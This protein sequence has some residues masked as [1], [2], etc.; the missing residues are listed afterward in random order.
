MNRKQ[1]QAIDDARRLLGL[2]D[3]ATQGEIKRAYHGLCKKYHPDVAGRQS[4]R[5]EEII[6]KL[7]HAY[8]LLVEYVDEF[9]FP[10]VPDEDSIYDAEDWW[11]DRFGSDPLWGKPRK[12]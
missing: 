1:W 6:Y 5:D 12:R 3:K 9:R 4:Q 10:L 8:K 11:M 7:T 2:A